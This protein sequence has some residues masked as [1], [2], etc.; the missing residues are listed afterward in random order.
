MASLLSLLPRFTSKHIVLGSKSPRR[1]E[2]L[3]RALLGVDLEIIGSSF[4][5]DLDKAHFQTPV[6]LPSNGLL[7]KKPKQKKTTL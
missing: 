6:S 2:I 5:E 1:K 4:E 3:E 7:K